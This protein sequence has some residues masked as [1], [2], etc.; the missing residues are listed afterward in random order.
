VTGTGAWGVVLSTSSIERCEKPDFS[1]F[2]SSIDLF[3]TAAVAM[4]SGYETID[5]DKEQLKE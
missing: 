5:G 4:L 3:I 1:V 2:R